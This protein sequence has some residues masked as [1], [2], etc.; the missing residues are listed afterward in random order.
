MTEKYVEVT[1]RL[2][3]VV[4]SKPLFSN[5]AYSKSP[6]SLD[7]PRICDVQ[8]NSTEMKLLLHWLDSICSQ[9]SLSEY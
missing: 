2:L 7:H 8:Q 1:L 5:H 6:H 3:L 4:N 9:E